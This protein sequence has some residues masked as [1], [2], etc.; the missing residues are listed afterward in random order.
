MRYAQVKQFAKG[1]LIEQSAETAL[2]VI[3]VTTLPQLPCRLTNAE[4]MGPSPFE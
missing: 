3:S 1:S 2:P 4:D